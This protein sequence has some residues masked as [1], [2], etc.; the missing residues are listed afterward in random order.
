M[1]DRVKL[2]RALICLDCETIYDQDE[3]L[4]CPQCASR[5]TWPVGKWIVPANHRRKNSETEKSYGWAVRS[6]PMY[7]I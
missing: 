6:C 3:G 1:P 4:Y 2:G 5:I 7:K